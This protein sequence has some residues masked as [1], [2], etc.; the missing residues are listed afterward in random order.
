MS[1]CSSAAAGKKRLFKNIFIVWRI[2]SQ[3]CKL[4]SYISN[5]KT[6]QNYLIEKVPGDGEQD[7]GEEWRGERRLPRDERVQDND[8]VSHLEGEKLKFC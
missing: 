6:R 1:R 2:W 3:I 8:A 5:Q 4:F 7:L